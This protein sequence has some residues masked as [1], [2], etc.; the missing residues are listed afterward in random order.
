MFHLRSATNVFAVLAALAFVAGV[1]VEGVHAQPSGLPPLVTRTHQAM[2]TEIRFVVYT[3]DEPKALRAFADGFAEFQRLES[4]MTTWR[5]DSEVSRI[6]AQAGVAPVKVSPETLEVIEMSDRASK[7]SNG[8]F[9]ITFYA[10]HG[11]G[12]FDDDMV[13]QVP[14]AAAI[15]RRLVLVDYRKVIIDH[16]AST[17]ML[18]DKG[19]AINLGGIAKGYAV[20]R[21]AAILKSAGF[22]D[23]LVQAGGDLMCVGNKFG[24]PWT[25]GIRDPRGPRDAVFAVMKLEDHA[26]STAGDYER[27]FMLD[28]KRYHHILDPKTGRP[29]MASKSVTIY[30]PNAFL[31]DAVDDAVF[32][33]GWKKGIEMVE[34]L[35]DV[36]AVVVDADGKVHISKRV[37]A[38]VNLLREPTPGP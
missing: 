20:D 23:A 37:E 16:A 36:G 15:K 33:L 5:A 10:L 17:V 19:M 35:P 28:G 24:Q 8:A 1:A 27:F 14:E 11:L 4:L 6:N 34:S 7:M 2:G 13:K 12:K 9:D 21:A 25:T 30:A 3:T 31:A 18:K 29:A 26:F 32:I 38:R 22:K